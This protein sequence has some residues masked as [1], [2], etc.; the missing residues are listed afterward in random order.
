MNSDGLFSGIF[1]G[2]RAR[3]DMEQVGGVL[4]TQVWLRTLYFKHYYATHVHI[5]PASYSTF[6]LKLTHNDH[7]KAF[8]LCTSQVFSITR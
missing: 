7:W 3:F 1:Q 8:K 4:Q 2:M 6:T 5:S